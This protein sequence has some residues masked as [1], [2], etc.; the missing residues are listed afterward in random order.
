[1]IACELASALVVALMAATVPPLPVLAALVAAA[2]ALATIRNP[3]GRSLVPILVA[4]AD[5]APAN[6]LFGLAHTLQL[7][8]GPVLGGMLAAGPGFRTALAVDVLTFI[9]SAL[10]LGRLPA[11]PPTR[12]CAASTGIWTEAW[13]GLRYVGRHRQVRVLVL[14]L[15]VVVTFAAVDNV[16]LVFLTRHT[17]AAGAAGYGLAA[18]AFG[19]GMLLASTACT[20]LA[21]DRSPT[22]LLIIAV[23]VTGAGTVITGL[24]PVIALAVVAQLIAGSGNAVEN[25]SY[26]TLVQNLVPRPFLAR[27]FGTIGTAAQLGAGLAYA[28]GGP[29]VDLIG[30]RATFILAGAGTLAVLPVLLHATRH[31]ADAPGP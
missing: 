25:I 31:G 14:T 11:L 27:V 20:R 29:L 6:A 17:L 12:D 30:A 9:A 3:A 19:V 4:P 24:A 13:S 15:F 1:M 26:D 23:A 8:A 7:A 22:V 10:L 21:R 28:A 5:R 18:S 16:A 2:G